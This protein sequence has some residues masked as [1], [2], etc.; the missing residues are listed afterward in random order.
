VLRHIIL[1][2]LLLQLGCDYHPSNEF[3]DWNGTDSDFKNTFKLLVGEENNGSFLVEKNSGKIFSGEVNRTDSK[4]ITNQT[5]SSG[6]LN[7]KSIKS[8]PDGS[9]VEAH[10][11]NGQLDGE[12]IFYGADGKVKSVMNYKEGRLV[13]PTTQ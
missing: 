10:Y 7:G 11:L 5:F 6:R 12:M 8:S 13:I 4:W 2:S 1:F 3:D 9:W